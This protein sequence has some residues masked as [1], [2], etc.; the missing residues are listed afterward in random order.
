MF[1]P[2]TWFPLRNKTTLA[3]GRA[4]FESKS[5]TRPFSV[6]WPTC[7]TALKL[8]RSAPKIVANRIM[9]LE[10]S[11]I[12]GIGA[13]YRPT[14]LRTLKSAKTLQTKGMNGFP[15]FPSRFNPISVLF[16]AAPHAEPL[17]PDTFF[18]PCG[19]GL[20]ACPC[21]CVCARCLLV[22]LVATLGSCAAPSGTI[23]VFRV[24]FAGA[25]SGVLEAPC[26][27]SRT[28]S[29]PFSRPCR[30]FIRRSSAFRSLRDWLSACACLQAPHHP[31]QTHQQHHRAT[32]KRDTN[33]RNRPAFETRCNTWG[34]GIRVKARG[35]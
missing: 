29:S 14:P 10:F 7:A 35:L 21:A 27:S 17:P 22:I 31:A 6:P 4:S 34:L 13:K 32:C 1:V 19:V 5:V 3:K 16:P 9:R 2:A 26:S 20:F 33:A 24:R 8:I 18:R 23:E 11:G 30:F 12:T 25:C 15:G 28:P